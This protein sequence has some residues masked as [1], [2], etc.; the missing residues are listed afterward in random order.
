MANNFN[1][2]FYSITLGAS[3]T[4][5]VAEGFAVANTDGTNTVNY[6]VMTSESSG[7]I[8]APTISIATG[9]A[10]SGMIPSF[11]IVQGENGKRGG[12]MKARYL[13]R[14][15][16]LED[17]F[18][19]G[20]LRVF[21]DAVTPVGTDIQVYYKVLGSED[22]ERFDDKSWVLMYKKV[23]KKSK[24]NRQIIDLEFRPDL[25]ENKL[26]YVENGQQYPIGGKFKHFAVKVV[27]MAADT[28]VVPMVQNLRIIATP[29]G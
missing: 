7:Y 8:T 5:G 21:M 23:D 20:D 6:I 15:I 22:P 4:G 28:T 25:M 24:D 14:Q 26:K 18:E 17:G 11:A 1:I 10:A 13:T 16:A 2:G 3:S 19:A 29:E 27:L 9:N 12:N